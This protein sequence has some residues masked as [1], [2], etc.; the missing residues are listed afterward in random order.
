MKVKD[1]FKWADEEFKIEMELMR[2]KGL[3]AY[4]F[5]TKLCV[6]WCGGIR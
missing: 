5:Y 2:V 4:G 1:F 6:K 3:K